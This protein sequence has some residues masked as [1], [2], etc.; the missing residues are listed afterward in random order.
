M[1]VVIADDEDHVRKGIELDVDWERFGISERLMA[2]DGIQA[3]ELIREHNPAIL[4]CDMSMPRMDGIALLRMLREEGWDTQVIVVSGYDDFSYT[5]AAILAN[6]VDYI[7]KPFKTKDLEGAV[8]RA[9]TAYQATKSKTKDEIETRHRLHLADS[10]LDEQ[11]WSQY[12]K[13][14]TSFQDQTVRHLFHKTGL[15][16][17]NLYVSCI[18]PRNRHQLV[19]QKFSGDIGLFHFAVNN[20]AHDILKSYG[21]HYLVRMDDYHWV[22]ITASAKSDIIVNEY[23]WYLDKLSRVW[24]ETLGLDVLQGTYVRITD[25][26]RMLPAMAEARASLLKR[27]LMKESPSIIGELPRFADREIPLINAIRKGNKTGLTEII[28]AF[29]ESLNPADHCAWRSFKYMRWKPTSCSSE[30]KVYIKRTRNGATGLFPYGSA[31]W[32]NGRRS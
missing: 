27:E 15:P 3:M 7:L 24:R 5:R 16:L 30:R 32:T 18:L 2:D 14:E 8:S 4:F 17:Q 9:V 6:G 25:Y 29:V 31:I 1:K 19:Y 28:E 26:T 23:S 10:L 11:K 12:L 20:I 21:P 13:G 22:L